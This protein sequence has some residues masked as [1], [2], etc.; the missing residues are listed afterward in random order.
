MLNLEESALVFSSAAVRY[1]SSM[2]SVHLKDMTDYFF[3]TF[4]R[5]FHTLISSTLS[6]SIPLSTPHSLM[7]ILFL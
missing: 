2:T 6:L 1:P 5:D 4:I 3:R 7:S